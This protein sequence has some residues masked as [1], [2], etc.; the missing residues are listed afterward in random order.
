[1]FMMETQKQQSGTGMDQSV[2]CVTITPEYLGWNSKGHSCSVCGS[3]GNDNDT[4]TL[5]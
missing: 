1:M 3:G 4:R 2:L 5:G